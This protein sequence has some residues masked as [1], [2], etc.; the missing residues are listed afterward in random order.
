MKPLKARRSSRRWGRKMQT[1]ITSGHIVHR[2]NH[3]HNDAVE[4]NMGKIIGGVAF[5]RGVYAAA[6]DPEAV[7]YMAGRQPGE[8]VFFLKGWNAGNAQARL[9]A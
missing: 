7:A 5:A 3:T 4:Y 6:M 1:Q 9:A 8:S 2:I